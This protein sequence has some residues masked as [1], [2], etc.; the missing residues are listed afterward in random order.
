MYVYDQANNLA[1]A[2]QESKEYKDYK[3][4]KEEVNSNVEM[5][6][7]IDEFEKIRYEVQALSKCKSYKKCTK[8]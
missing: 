8:Y 1:K 6:K 7:Q 3:R 2:I 4:V 5:K